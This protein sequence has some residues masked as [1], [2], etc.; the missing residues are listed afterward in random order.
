M[1]R[2][3]PR[4]AVVTT[5]VA[6]W[7]GTVVL[8]QQPTGPRDA[9]GYPA[10]TAELER[11]R[12]V[13]VLNHCH[14]CHGVDLTRSVMG[15]TDLMRSGIVAADV[16]GSLI[17][18]LV[19]AGRPDLQ[20][21]MPS[22]TELTDTEL[23]EMSRYIHFLRQ[24]GRYLQL[25][26]EPVDDGDAVAGR[27]LFANRCASCHSLTGDLQGIATR[28]SPTVLRERMLQPMTATGTPAVTSDNA[29]HRQ[30]GILLERLT[31]ADVKNLV[32]CLR[33]PL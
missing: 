22:Y 25:T 9:G 5:G 24:R 28:Y 14:F 17:G 7:L 27:A 33:S 2:L 12:A 31:D 11:G 21:S 4:R 16:D 32:A 3:L 20:T 8:A 15:A 23:R 10:P 13:Y 30:H 1:S 29:G 18:P 19:R 6:V 26:A